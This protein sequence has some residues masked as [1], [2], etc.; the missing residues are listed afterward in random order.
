MLEA[1]DKR[2]P[3]DVRR[4]IQGARSFVWMLMLAASMC[5]LVLVNDMHA[6]TAMMKLIS[7]AIT[8]TIP[9]DPG[10]T[11]RKSRRE[12]LSSLWDAVGPVAFPM[13]GSD[14][15]GRTILLPPRVRTVVID[16]GARDSDYLAALESSG[17]PTVALFLIDPLP[18]SILPLQRRAAAHATKEMVDGKFL[19][20]ERQNIF[21][22][23]AALGQQEGVAMFNVASGPACGSLLERNEASKFWCTQVKQR[24]RVTILTLEG[25]LRLV[26][27]RVEEF[28]LKVDAEGADLMV[29]QGA[30]DAIR[31]FQT[32]II[33]CMPDDNGTG[34]EVAYHV[35]GCQLTPARK[36]MELHGFSVE[37][38]EQ[39]GLINMFFLNR[40]KTG[41]LPDFL[42]KQGRLAYRAWYQNV[43]EHLDRL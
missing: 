12:S 43:S 5:A 15:R 36:Y 34:S 4:R 21:A 3:P 33:E 41:P 32:V 1:D 30:G 25:L 35:G 8:T 37:W 10:K 2:A 13:E 14:E 23:K 29:L 39:G 7:A 6:T 42:S 27:A 38:H 31:R 16:V 20:E 26:P 40:N 11:A 24:L 19:R 17:D 9:D 22:V 28:H 18:G